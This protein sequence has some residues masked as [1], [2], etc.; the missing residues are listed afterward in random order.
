MLCPAEK[1]EGALP[2]R[3]CDL[4]A[5]EGVLAARLRPRRLAGRDQRHRKPTGAMRSTTASAKVDDLAGAADVRAHSCHSDIPVGRAGNKQHGQGRE[6]YTEVFPAGVH[7]FARGE[8][9][10]SNRRPP[11]AYPG[12]PPG[13]YPKKAAVTVVG[14]PRVK[15]HVP[16]PEQ[17]PDQAAKVTPSAGTALSVTTVP[18]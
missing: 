6:S 16:V 8:R 13:S 2:G 4:R 11:G 12:G 9:P 10:D 15:V 5:T 1:H 18:C 7:G 3:P 17:G 14:P